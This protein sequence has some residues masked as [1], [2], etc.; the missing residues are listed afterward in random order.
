MSV[1]PGPLECVH[2]CVC[3][4]RDMRSYFYFACDS[5]CPGY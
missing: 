4:K 5:E 2:V 3:E 1:S